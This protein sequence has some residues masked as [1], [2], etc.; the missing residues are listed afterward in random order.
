MNYKDKQVIYVCIKCKRFLFCYNPDWLIRHNNKEGWGHTR[1][2]RQID[3]STDNY[4]AHRNRTL[5]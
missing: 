5:T 3:E 4:V 1:T 2:C